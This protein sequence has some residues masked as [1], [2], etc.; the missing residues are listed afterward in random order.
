MLTLDARTWSLSANSQGTNV[1]ASSFMVL[2]SE[3]RHS[4]SARALVLGLPS[5]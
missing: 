5:V 4:A 1:K 3:I 2:P